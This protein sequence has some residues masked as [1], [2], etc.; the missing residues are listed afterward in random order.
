MLVSK[1]WLNTMVEVNDIKTSELGEILTNAGLEVE[2]IIPLLEATDLV[3]GEVLE[4]IPHPDSDHLSVTQV[5]VGTETLQIV[6]GAPNVQSGQKVIVAKVGAKLPGLTIK[7]AKVR[8]VESNGMICSLLELGVDKELLPV[9]SGSHEGIEVLGDDAVAGEDPIAYLAL[10]DEVL[11]VSL[12]PNRAD[13]MA[14]QSVG[15]EVAALLDRE[16]KEP[17]VETDVLSGLPSDFQVNSTTEN[18]HLFIAK[19]I[20]KVSVKPSPQWIQNAL[21]AAGMNPIN[22]LVD[23]SNLV[24][25][26]T[27]Q[28]THFYDRD[29]FEVDDITVID[30][31]EG[32]V[33]A[34]DNQEY[35]IQKGDTIISMAGKP[36]GIAGIKGL[37]NSM[38]KPDTKAMVIEIASFDSLAIRNTSKRLNLM[39][40][41]QARYIK[42]MDSEAPRKALERILYLLKK[43]GDADE[44][45]ETKV[46][47]SL[48][49]EQHLKVS[50]SFEHVNNLL[51][52]HLKD[53]EIVGV[54]RRL[55]FAP[56]VAERV[57]TCTIPSYRKDL[58][59][60][61][62]LIEEVIRVVG[63]DVI[64]STLPEMPLTQG[65]LT[66]EQHLI[67]KAEE[68]LVGFGAQQVVS[69]TLVSKEHTENAQALK[70]PY[71]LMSPL[72][73]KRKYIR[74]NLTT[75]LIPTLKYNLAHQNVNNLY[76]EISQVYGQGSDEW[77]LGLIGDG[78][79]GRG[80]YNQ[81]ARVLDFS[82]IKG[83][84][85]SLLSELGINTNRLSYEENVLDTDH[86]H[87]YRSAQVFL[88]K[89]YLGILGEIHP[90]ITKGAL[91]ELNLSL[92]MSAKKAKTKYKP[93]NKYPRVSRDI[94]LMINED[95]SHDLLVRVIKQA[96]RPYLVDI[97]L[98]D[99]YEKDG[100]KSMA[101]T[102]SFES[103]DK[104]LVDEEISQII[105]NILNSLLK[106][107]NVTL[108]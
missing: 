108:R 60:A 56:V 35:S 8:G 28:P 83:L 9:D 91:S 48:E 71:A 7:E 6:C 37:G 95:V 57:V 16:Y 23:I 105:E 67:R 54:F 14:M 85:E 70:D 55:N 43:Y 29:F 10:D 93:L 39:S 104:T 17:A 79:L 22:N 24:M 30:N 100:N 2:G 44:I 50:V 81:V 3:I 72:S 74:N 94:A 41:S 69:Y 52:T 101:F 42:P 38:I 13:F 26:E 34:L 99:I 90:S 62:D 96:G 75:S 73:D 21:M 31:F 87:P 18:C 86:Y 51:G 5:N 33:I 89:K 11:D 58:F 49:R 97:N 1:K 107:L 61:E 40:D 80:S 82:Y 98:F 46:Y 77:R 4:A 78:H 103:L 106:E 68:L 25:L 12:T 47:G 66:T 64:E 36:I 45:Y 53:E 27:G 32:S 88:D 15:R 65:T 92:V 20:G 59:I 84:L 102:L 19:V 76:F 63:Y